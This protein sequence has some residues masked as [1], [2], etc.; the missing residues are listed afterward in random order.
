MDELKQERFKR[1]IS[2]LESSGGKNLNHKMIKTG[3]HAGDRAIG[4]YGLMPLT[5][6]D[7]AKMRINR[8]IGDE[9]DK[10]IAKMSLEDAKKQIPEIIKQNPDIYEKYVDTLVDH[11]LKRYGDER[12]AAFAWNQGHYSDPKVLM[13][14]LINPKTKLQAEYLSRIEKAASKINDVPS[15]SEKKIESIVNN[16]VPNYATNNNVEIPKG[17][18]FLSPSG[19][20][21]ADEEPQEEEDSINLSSKFRRI[22]N[23][24]I[25]PKNIVYRKIKKENEG[26]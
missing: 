20:F 9:L 3:I 24:L 19:E 21:I 17:M 5:I 7:A 22:K 23:K 6:Q 10:K 11:V 2:H 1:I 16:L 4:E 13:D 26:T 14:R 8:G 18:V 25:D 12:L 15:E